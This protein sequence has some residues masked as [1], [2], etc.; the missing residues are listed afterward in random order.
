[1]AFLFSSS[2]NKN[3]AK[4]LKEFTLLISAISLSIIEKSITPSAIFFA[5]RYQQKQH[6]DQIDLVEEKFNS[7]TLQNSQ[8]E[9]QINENNNFLNIAQ[10]EIKNNSTNIIQVYKRS[11][12]N[13]RNNNLVRGKLDRIEHKQKSNSLTISQHK[14]QI[15][16]VL[17]KNKQLETQINQ[18]KNNKQLLSIVKPLTKKQNITTH[19]CIDGNN[20]YQGIQGQ[21]LH[22][23]PQRF[24]LY[25]SEIMGEFDRIQLNY[26]TGLSKI[27]NKAEKRWLD[28]FIK[29]G[30]QVIKLPVVSRKLS[31]DKTLGDD[32]R[33][34]IDL[35]ENVQENDRV[36]LVSGDG[37]FLPLVEK[38]LAKNIK[39]TLIGASNTISSQW[40][41]YFQNNTNFKLITLESIAH[42]IVNLRKL[43]S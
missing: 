12:N 19:V 39:V 40:S 32:V 2:P 31:P 36:V 5:Y 16:L 22:I 13:Q 30:Y 20:F 4:F 15:D 34:S 1:M 29:L 41:R 35:V 28:D 38:L 14:K 37:D 21:N 43:A 42:K 8:L 6:Q 17:E 9:S 23:D 11:R 25:L 3:T 24:T 10:Q 26:Y 7:V 27:P 18:Q 33:L